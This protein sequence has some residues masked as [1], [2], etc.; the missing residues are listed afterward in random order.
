MKDLIKNFFAFGVATALEKILSFILLPIYARVFSVEE[1]GIVDLT[2]TTIGIVSIFA[3]LQLETALQRF[4]YE[5]NK[6]DKRDLIFTI[7]TIITFLAIFISVILVAFAYPL[8]RKLYSENGFELTFIVAALQIPFS[9]LYMV[10]LLVLRFEKRNK[11]FIFL[12]VSKAALLFC[13]ALYLVVYR[14]MGV[15]GLFLS[16]FIAIACTAIYAFMKIKKELSFHFSFTLAKKSLGYAL[17][18]FPARI[19]STTIASANRYFIVG[20][21]STFYVGLFSMALKLGAIMLL[22]HQVFMMAWNQFIFEAIKRENHKQIFS[23]A[24]DIII[25]LLFCVTALLTLFSYEIIYYV[26]TADYIEAYKYVGWISFS[27]V[28]LSCKEMVDI[29][30][31]YLMKTHILSVNF[32]ISAAFNIASLAIL[33][34]IYKLNGVIISMVSTNILLFALSWFNSRRLYYIPFNMLKF[35]FSTVPLFMV[36]FGVQFD[37]F[38]SLF[39]RVEIS[40]GIILIYSYLFI[41]A[42]HNYKRQNLDS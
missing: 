4:Y 30:P 9:S 11:D 14:K 5:L 41:L 42:L 23:A 33:L 31:K 15:L 20:I 6:K 35:G 26:A 36:L 24:F 29:G 39:L 37:I 27:M 18:Q 16:Q 3:L 40:I 22:F 34:P 17:P 38:D 8:S 21:L 10:S 25:P 1:F 13:L 19:G 7:A 2:Q 12:A 32:I 28:L